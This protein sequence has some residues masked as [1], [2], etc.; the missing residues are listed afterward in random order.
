MALNATDRRQFQLVGL[1]AVIA[2]LLA[3]AFVVIARPPGRSV[4]AY[5]TSA[6]A[7]FEDNSVRVLGVDVGSIDRVIPEGT[8]VRVEMTIDDPDLRLPAD[9][10]AVVISPSLVT[11]RYVQLTPTYS[12]GPEL[13]D[14]AVIPVERTAVPLD[15]DDLART[16]T[17]LTDALGPNG[18]NA[19]GSLSRVLD[20]GA[21]NLGGNGQALNDTITDLGELSGTLADSREELFGTV[22]ELQRF[23]AV[24]AA[25][26]AEV[27]E[28]NTRLEDVA[29]FLADERGDLGD[30]LR[31]LSIALGEVAVFVRDNREIL[32]SNVDRLTEVTGVLVGQQRALAET[33]DTAP[34]ALS[35]LANAYNGSSGTLDTRANINELTLPPLVLICELLERGTPEAL[36]E[37]PV[38]VADACEALGPLEALPLPS[39]AEVITSL[40]AGEVPPVPGLALP[41]APAGPAAAQPARPLDGE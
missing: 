3:T 17:D 29:A 18:V 6:T 13:V 28:F 16:A 7:V 27:R 11:G 32:A 19:D 25:N 39:A 34:N 10:R 41:T 33:L 24:I 21:A 20:V 36:A 30:A 22:T 9:A 2:V 15:V 40:Q 5:F 12:G 35:N 38:G 23:V 8:R 26:D 4:V 1:V 37:L 31:E 14:G